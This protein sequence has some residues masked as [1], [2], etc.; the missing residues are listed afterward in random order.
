MTGLPLLAFSLLI[1]IVF[2]WRLGFGDME[3]ARVGIFAGAKGEL[4]KE[5]L[6][7]TTS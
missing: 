4:V 5:L 2:V 7:G 1:R 3:M 6:L